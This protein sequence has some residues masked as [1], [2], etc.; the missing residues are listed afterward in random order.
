MRGKWIHIY[1]D[2]FI[3]HKWKSSF[4]TPMFAPLAAVNRIPKMSTLQ[5]GLQSMKMACMRGQIS[6]P[7]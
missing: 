2:A 7:R 6:S 3:I 4:Q 5:C 1:A